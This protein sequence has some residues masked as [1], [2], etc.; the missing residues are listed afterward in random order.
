MNKYQEFVNT[1][2]AYFKDQVHID[3]ILINYI[4]AQQFEKVDSYFQQQF[5][6][7]GNLRNYLLNFL[8]FENIEFI[9]SI[10]NAKNE[11]EEDGIWHD[12]GSRKLAFS[13]S[14]YKSDPIQGGILEI[15][16]KGKK[17][18]EKI[19]PFDFGQIII[20]KT[21][22]HNFEHKINAVTKGKRIV[23]AGWCS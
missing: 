17:E 7:K 22:Y 21:G 11:W 23:I 6:P 9:I 20:F 14:I 13:L 8:P 19:S 3:T 1:K 5:S 15:R 2:K 4:K 16:Q 10:R 12:D 18:S